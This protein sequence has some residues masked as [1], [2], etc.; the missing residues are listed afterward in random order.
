M[1]IIELE[2]GKVYCE[3]HEISMRKMNWMLMGN[4]V[5]DNKKIQS[6]SNS[7]KGVSLGGC[8]N[9]RNEMDGVSRD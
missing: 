6:A 4:W 3:K 9:K 7:L 1:T 5:I 8:D 2:R